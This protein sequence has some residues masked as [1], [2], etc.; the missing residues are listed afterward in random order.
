MSLRKALY[1]LLCLSVYAI[2]LWVL[3]SC[4]KT[5]SYSLV[6]KDDYMGYL[7]YKT[8]DFYEKYD[9][10]SI[11]LKDISFVF[12]MGAS[13]DLTSINYEFMIIRQGVIYRGPFE[14]NI[15]VKNVP[16]IMDNNLTRINTIS[17]ALLDHTICTSTINIIL[18]L[19][20]TV[21]FRLLVPRLF[22]NFR[23]YIGSLLSTK[24]RK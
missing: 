19:K 22:G 11:L 1:L 13:I 2:C 14:K 23:I 12:D 9:A 10:D 21:S 5:D 3:F 18:A 20:I 4:K 8:S 7:H 16:F 6:S 17:F 15:T 24:N